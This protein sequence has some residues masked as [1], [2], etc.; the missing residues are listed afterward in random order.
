M[1]KYK[2]MKDAMNAAQTRIREYKR[3][4]SQA[5]K[6]NDMARAKKLLIAAHSIKVKRVPN[7]AEVLYEIKGM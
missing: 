4:I 7:T 1:V 5:R 2:S 3:Q 6:H